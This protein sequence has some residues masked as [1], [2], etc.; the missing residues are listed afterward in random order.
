VAGNMDVL[1]LR[2]LL[3]GA[4]HVGTQN[5]NIASFLHFDHLGADTIIHVSSTGGF[6]SGYSA[7]QED[8]TI[9]LKNVDLT[10][11]GTQTDQQII[12]QLLANGQLH[13]G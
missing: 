3:G 8:E 7:T 12:H 9:V 2:D 4:N 5:G 10:A 11:S 6:A 1:D 13:L